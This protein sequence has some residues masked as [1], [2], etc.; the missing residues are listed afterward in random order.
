MKKAVL[1]ISILFAG[2]LIMGTETSQAETDHYQLAMGNII[3]SYLKIRKRLAQDS[4]SGVATWT[5]EII[6]H[7]RAAKKMHTEHPKHK[8][9]VHE[10]YLLINEAGEHAAHLS[11]GSIKAVRQHFAELSKPIIKYVEKFGHPH[12]TSEKLFAYY[13]PM[14]PGYWLQESKDAANPLYGKTML[15]CAT[16]VE[17]AEKKQKMLHELGKEHPQKQQMEKEHHL[18]DKEHKH[19]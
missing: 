2:C 14:Y 9:E 1:L 4:L 5:Q 3:N 6:H 15:K 17:G 12:N 18:E 13:C 19:M 16:L 8:Q 10:K 7:V 11:H